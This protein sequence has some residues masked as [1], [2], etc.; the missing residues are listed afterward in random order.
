VLRRWLDRDVPTDSATVP[1]ADRDA[2]AS[3]L[4]IVRR[5]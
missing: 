1:Q 4:P 5:R 2:A 3:P